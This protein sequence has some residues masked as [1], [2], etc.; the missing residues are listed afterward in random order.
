MKVNCKQY[1]CQYS[2]S[3]TSFIFCN[4]L[5]QTSRAKKSTNSIFCWNCSDSKA[6][7]LWFLFHI[8]ISLEEMVFCC[9]VLLSLRFPNNNN[10]AQ[11]LKNCREG[12]T[13]TLI[14]KKDFWKSRVLF[15]WS[16][17]KYHH[18]IRYRNLVSLS[19][20]LFPAHNMKFILDLQLNLYTPWDQIISCWTC[21]AVK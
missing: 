19:F 4:F 15:M 18:N 2:S 20:L 8:A 16:S 17:S 11:L 10:E 14:W 6:E 5:L 13:Q 9:D 12:S 7:K 3:I 1:K 21:W